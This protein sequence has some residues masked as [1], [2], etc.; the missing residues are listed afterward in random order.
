MHLPPYRQ[1][2]H[3][4]PEGGLAHQQGCLRRKIHLHG[5]VTARQVFL[6][7]PVRKRVDARFAFHQQTGAFFDLCYH[8]I[9]PI[10]ALPGV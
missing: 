5:E 1:Q 4:A 9:G 8:T 10:E 3:L 2:H 7:G 6:E